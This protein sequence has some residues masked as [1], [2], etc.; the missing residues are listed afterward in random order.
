MCKILGQ[1][2]NN[3]FFTILPA[4]CLLQYG[5]SHISRTDWLDNLKELLPF[6]TLN[7]SPKICKHKSWY[8][9]IEIPENFAYMPIMEICISLWLFDCSIFKGVITFFTFASLLLISLISIWRFV[10]SS[11]CMIGSYLKELL[12]FSNLEYYIKMIRIAI[13]HTF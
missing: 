4:S 11:S 13:P 2:F 5:R 6:L 12:P 7:I 10:Y 1:H 8:I 3:E 9:L